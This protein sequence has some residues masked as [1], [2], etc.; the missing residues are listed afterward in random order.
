M[1]HESMRNAMQNS[2]PSGWCGAML[3]VAVLWVLGAGTGVANAQLNGGGGQLPAPVFDP[4]LVFNVGDIHDDF[5]FGAVNPYGLASADFL[6]ADGN[7]GQDGYPEIAVAGTGVNMIDPATRWCGNSPGE[8]YVMVFHNK[9]ATVNWDGTNGDDPL[10]A[11][12]LVDILPI[13]IA[14]PGMWAMELAFA[15]VTGANGPDLVLVGADPD[16]SI[17]H[18][19][20]YKNLGNGSF[21][22]IPDVW[23]TTVPFRGLI[24]ADLDLD[25]RID[26]AASSADLPGE[27]DCSTAEQDVVVVFQN[28]TD[29]NGLAFDV[30]DPIDLGTPFDRAP[31][32]LALADFTALAPGQPLLDLATPNPGAD[33]ITAITNLGMMNFVPITVSPPTGCEWRYVSAVGARFG[34]DPHWDIAAVHTADESS[35]DPSD[36]RVYV[37]LLQGDGLGSFQSPCDTPPGYQLDIQ[38]ENPALRAHGI[39]SGFIDNGPYPDVVVATWR[40]PLNLASDS[41]VAVLLGRG[42]GTLQA[43]SDEQAYLFN[44]EERHT[45]NVMLVDL[46]ADGFD[47]IVAANHWHDGVLKRDTIS[48]FIN[49]LEVTGSGP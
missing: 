25:G 16:I 10:D 41:H 39:D 18:L 12:E 22:S 27:W 36:W 7:P 40:F 4:V 20:V 33:G 6:D 19:L 31:G 11:L 45:I 3:A 14:A 13:H 32:D 43:A 29:Q 49:S 35:N 26:I 44:T 1:K 34:A 2:T 5:D 47:D 38:G 17:G 30:L 15:D 48:I 42:N 21:N 9:G 8:H 37:D 23:S 46:D 24:T 28:L